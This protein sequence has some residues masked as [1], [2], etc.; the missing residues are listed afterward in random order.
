MSE[1]YHPD[2]KADK[3]SDFG[4]AYI[5]SKGKAHVHVVLSIKDNTENVSEYPIPYYHCPLCSITHTG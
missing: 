3:G 1:N 2:L 4:C 5:S